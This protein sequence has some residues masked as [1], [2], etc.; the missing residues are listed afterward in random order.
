MFI[1][2]KKKVVGTKEYRSTLLVE[3]VWNE[4]KKSP[5]HQT[6]MNL[7]KW[8]DTDV[9]AL[10]LALK[11]KRGFSLEELETAS[12]KSIGGLL[13]IKDI[14]DKLGITKALGTTKYAGLSMLLIAGRILTQGSRLKICEWGEL[15]EIEA[16]IGVSSFNED[17]LYETLDW[18]SENQSKIEQRIFKNRNPREQKMPAMYLYDITS[19][20]LEGQKNELG[21]YGYNRDGKRGKKQIVI[22]LMADK[23][24]IPV[25]VEVF[26][27]NTSDSTTVSSQIE[28][29][30]NRFG[31]D[32]LVFV[33]DRGMIKSTQIEAFGKYTNYITAITKDQIK[34]LVKKEIIQLELFQETLLEIEH[35]NIRY[36]TRR[37][38]I[39]AQEIQTNRAEKIASITE[40]INIANLY[41]KD[42]EKAK[43]KTQIIA[44]N[45]YISKLDISSLCSVFVSNQGEL[46]L[47]IDKKTLDDLV[48]LDGCYVIK[49]DLK[50]EELEASKVHQRYKDLAFVEKAFRTMKTACLEIRPIFVRKE[51]RTRGHVF[52]TSLAY[53]I[54]QDFWRKIKHIGLTLDHALQTINHLQTTIL[55]VKNNSIT[56]IPTPSKACQSILNALDIKLPDHLNLVVK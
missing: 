5:R 6:V 31:V 55:K 50:K 18:L 41:L 11:G 7:S 40:K 29:M 19:S 48:A 12:G 8:S 54:I 36:L 10:D 47:S 24:G 39:R 9:D 30:A 53:M 46:T 33:G 22:G 16:V 20:Y 23:E 52:V 45:K 35:E 28:K 49:T 27:G 34:T 3:S 26:K 51:S 21:R 38:P 2:R 32:K 14:A 37:N 42:H 17:R 13:V 44:L 15:Q 43:I 1:L 25:S 56:R 4:E